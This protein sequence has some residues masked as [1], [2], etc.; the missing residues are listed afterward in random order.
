MCFLMMHEAV[1]KR[2]ADNSPDH[3][4]L[5]SCAFFPDWKK[6]L[7]NHRVKKATGKWPQKQP[8]RSTQLYRLLIKKFSVMK[9]W[10]DDN[11]LIIAFCFYSSCTVCLFQCEVSI[12]F[13]I[14][15]RC[16]LFCNH[17]F[18]SFS[19]LSDIR[20]PIQ[21]AKKPKFQPLVTKVSITWQI[22]LI[23][24][25]CSNAKQLMLTI[26]VWPTKIM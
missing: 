18:N 26:Y 15:Y 22:T 19:V 20:E 24:I 21:P 16:K 9:N 2:E 23:K 8:V 5:C 3:W 17:E 10:V 11:K 13:E 12:I 7:T 1:Y 4:I 25:K 6:K 14:G